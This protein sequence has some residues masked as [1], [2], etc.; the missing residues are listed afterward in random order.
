MPHAKLICA[1]G[2][3]SPNRHWNQ[4][5]NF[6]GQ[7]KAIL[8]NWVC[9]CAQVVRQEAENFL[10]CMCV[11]FIIFRIHGHETFHNHGLHTWLSYVMQ[12]DS[13]KNYLFTLLLNCRNYCHRMESNPKSHQN[14][15]HRMKSISER[16]WKDFRTVLKHPVSS[17]NPKSIIG[18]KQKTTRG[19]M[20]SL[21]WVVP[22]AFFLK[23]PRP[24]TVKTT[25]Q[26]DRLGTVLG[27]VFVYLFSP[28]KIKM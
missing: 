4:R 13:R 2:T 16:F 14:S 15:M 5:K 12:V 20:D 1:Y 8:K 25:I 23:P 7:G 28:V 6:M 24:D 26:S 10:I 21:S 27:M 22:P 3:T 11:S 19:G 17:L 9:L 18:S